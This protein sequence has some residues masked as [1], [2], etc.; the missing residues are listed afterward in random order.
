MF[1]PSLT[2][3][4]A[5]KWQSSFVKITTNWSTGIRSQTNGEREREKTNRP[6]MNDKGKW[7]KIDNFEWKMQTFL[8]PMGKAI[9][10]YVPHFVQL[11]ESQANRKVRMHFCNRVRTAHKLHAQF[12]MPLGLKLDFENTD[13]NVFPF[14]FFLLCLVILLYTYTRV[15]EPCPD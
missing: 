11:C 14:R 9:N 5:K 12:I 15:L 7:P 4:Y 2:H 13:K 6:K 8:S 10:F 1:H 3:G